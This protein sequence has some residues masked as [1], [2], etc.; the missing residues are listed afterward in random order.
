MWVPGLTASLG[1]TGEVEV[2]AVQIISASAMVSSGDD[3]TRRSSGSGSWPAMSSTKDAALA[4]SRSN[5]QTVSIGLEVQIAYVIGHAKPVSLYVNTFGTGK[6][7]DTKIAKAV[8]RVFDLRPRKIIERLDLLRPIY[9]KTAAYGHFGRKE[10]GFTWEKTD[11]I[12][13]LKEEI[14]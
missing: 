4:E 12:G 14:R 13:A 1:N 6:Y 5:I 10:P 7:E 2:A 9:E 8:S 3:A 11:M